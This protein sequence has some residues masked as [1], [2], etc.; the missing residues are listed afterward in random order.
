MLSLTRKG[1]TDSRKTCNVTVCRAEGRLRNNRKTAQ[2]CRKSSGL[3]PA[4]ANGRHHWTGEG[5]PARLSKVERKGFPG[6]SQQSLYQR[7]HETLDVEGQL[8]KTL[9]DTGLVPNLKKI[10]ICSGSAPRL[11]PVLT[12]TTFFDLK[13][14]LVRNSQTYSPGTVVLEIGVEVKPEMLEEFTVLKSNVAGVCQPCDFTQAMLLLQASA[15]SSI[16]SKD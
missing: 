6:E 13:G 8:Q 12:Q 16:I 4:N 10:H 9:D 14:K 15:S 5:Q 11:Y 2:R 7:H 3:C 1:Q